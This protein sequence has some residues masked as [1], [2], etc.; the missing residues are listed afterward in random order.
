MTT[1]FRYFAVSGTFFSRPH[2]FSSALQ[3]TGMC[4]V[5]ELDDSGEFST[6]EHLLT[7]SDGFRSSSQSR[8]GA[9]DGIPNPQNSGSHPGRPG[10]RAGAT[11]RLRLPRTHPEIAGDHDPTQLCNDLL[12]PLKRVRRCS[13]V[14]NS[15]ESSNS[16]T[17]Y[18]PVIC[19][20]EEKKCSREKKVTLI[21]KS[22][23]EA[24]EVVNSSELR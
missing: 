19:N 24:N 2:F 11:T 21:A 22:A 1:S 4:L 7:R 16:S 15:L 13:W 23:S 18:I 17:G 9:L 12:K 14:L 20:A 8:G 10:C 3:V 5:F 6:Q